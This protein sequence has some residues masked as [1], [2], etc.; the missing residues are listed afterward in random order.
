MEKKWMIYGANGYT[1]KLV[2]EAAVQRQLKP[3]LAGRSRAAIE[4]LAAAF[5][6]PFKIVSLSDTQAL[7]RALQDIGIVSLCAGPFSATSE[8]M[9][10]AC[11]ANKVHYLDITGEIDVFVRAHSYHQQAQAAGV[12]LCP[13]MGFDVIPTDCI[14]SRLKEALPDAT[15]LALG[16]DS[17]GG[18]SPGTAKTSVEGLKTGNRIRRDGII[19]PVSL[20]YKVRE[21]DFGRGVKKAASIMWP[22]PFS[23]PVSP[24]SRCL[25]PAIPI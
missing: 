10:K 22:L 12:V 11:L 20:A 17:K 7:N 25:C 2:V 4:P 5:D 21:I 15:H 8:P 14:A 24:I 16:F 18:F 19:T 1:G 6:L 9:V 3:V 13:G 23:A